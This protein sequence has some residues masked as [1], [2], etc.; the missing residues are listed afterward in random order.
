M[1]ISVKTKQFPIDDLDSV[2][3][4]DGFGLFVDLIEVPNDC[5]FVRCGD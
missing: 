2:D 3:G 5:L 1:S 4:G